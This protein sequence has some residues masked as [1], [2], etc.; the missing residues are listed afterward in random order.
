MRMSFLIVALLAVSL[1]ST[2]DVFAQVNQTMR[3]MRTVYD[4]VQHLEFFSGQSDLELCAKQNQ[5]LSSATSRLYE[6]CSKDEERIQVA[7][8]YQYSQMAIVLTAD[9]L[10]VQIH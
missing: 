1:S 2:F 6:G 8:V 5:P 10:V 4:A 7:D 3:E 9:D